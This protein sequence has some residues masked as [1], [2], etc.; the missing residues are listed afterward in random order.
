MAVR[1][2]RLRRCLL[3]A[4]A[5]GC[6]HRGSQPEE[7]PRDPVLRAHV[8]AEAVV[9]IGR[10]D[11]R[12]PG[13]IPARP[14]LDDAAFELAVFRDG[15]LAVDAVACVGK[16]GLVV[17]RVSDQQLTALKALVDDVCFSLPRSER[18]CSHGRRTHFR[19]STLSRSTSFWDPCG[20]VGKEY[21]EQ[22]VRLLELEPLLIGDKAC[23]P[24]PVFDRRRQIE[25]TVWPERLLSGR[26]LAPRLCEMKALSVHAL[27]SPPGPGA[28]TFAYDNR[29][30]AIA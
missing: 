15:T 20:N 2:N 17:G 24:Q 12:E 18:S 22:V 27:R 28:R 14:R 29:P 11:D 3:V 13:V 9:F 19:C 7:G 21:I 4:V 1:S 23:G 26:P 6:A 16:P 10:P 25:R 5:I 8:G 30:A